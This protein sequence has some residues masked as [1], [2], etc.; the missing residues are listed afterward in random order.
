MY[1]EEKN[2]MLRY[3]Y[4][5]GIDRLV[6]NNRLLNSLPSKSKNRIHLLRYLG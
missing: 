3:L 6:R 5:A 4:T 2:V 1:C